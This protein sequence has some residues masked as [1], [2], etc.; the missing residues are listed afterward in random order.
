MSVPSIDSPI[1]QDAALVQR[2]REVGAQFADR[3]IETARVIAMVAAPTNDERDRAVLVADLFQTH[4]ASKVTTD[5]IH[6][7]VGRVAGKTHETAVLIAAH[8]DTVFSRETVLKIHQDDER[9]YGPGLGD[10]SLGVASVVFLPEMLAALDAV[11]ATDLLLTGNVGEEGLGNL[12]GITRVLTDHEDTGAVIAVEGQNLGRITHIAVG[13]VRLRITVTGPGG[14]SWGDFGNPSA[15]HAAARLIEQLDRIPLTQSPKTTL[16]VGMISGGIS[17]NSIAPSV[18]FDVDLR[19]TDPVALKRVV[20]RV[21]ATLTPRDERISVD[22][23]VLGKRPAGQVAVTS[24]IVVAA[25][26][27]LRSLSHSPAADASST[28][29]NAAIAMGLPAVC[30]GLTT[31]GN[32][33]R[34]DEYIDLAPVKTGLAQLILLTLAVSEDLARGRL[35]P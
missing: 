9:G 13:S 14:H 18:T 21:R 25:A 7:V 19:S 29:A 20:D 5:D 27:I 12:R 10:N 15:I 33:H 1:W 26:E 28:D 3:V 24:R 22:I 32:A 30:I 17:I 23:L 2:A 6:D 16:N 34:L 35:A 11:P 8:T 4:G 31:G